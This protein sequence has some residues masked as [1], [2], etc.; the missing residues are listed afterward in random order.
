TKKEGDDEDEAPE[1]P[2]LPDV[3]ETGR[4]L[5]AVGEGVDE[6]EMARI[7]RSMRT[8]AMANPSAENL[9]FW[10]KVS[11]KTRP[12]YVIECTMAEYPE[13]EGE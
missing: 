13:G 9:Q 11:T 3:I 8:F 10:G 5:S 1:E 4:M 2:A 6:G 12:Y 7:F